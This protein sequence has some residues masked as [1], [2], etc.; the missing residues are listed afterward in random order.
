MHLTEYERRRRRSSS[1]KNRTT[2]EVQSIDQP[3][4]ERLTLAASLPLM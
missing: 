1:S 4:R 2:L 3:Q